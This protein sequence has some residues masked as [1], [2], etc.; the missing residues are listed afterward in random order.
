MTFRKA[1]GL[2]VVGVALVCSCQPLAPRA[3]GDHATADCRSLTGDGATV[4]GR[5]A[6][7][8]PVVPDERVHVDLDAPLGST[9]ERLTGVV[10]N[11]GNS[12][13]P[14]EPVHPRLVRIDASLQSRSPAPGVLDLQPLLDRVAQVRAIG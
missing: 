5:V 14:L 4:H 7:V 3:G 6:R 1:M 2:L 8:A 11:S 13:E 10:W 9:N 12:I